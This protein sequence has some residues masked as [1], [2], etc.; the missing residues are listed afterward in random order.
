MN[1]TESDNLKCTI[2]NVGVAVQEGEKFTDE[3]GNTIEEDGLIVE[4]EAIHETITSNFTRYTAKGMKLGLESWTTPYNKPVIEHHD[5]ER[6]S[7][8]GRVLKAEFKET[9]EAGLPCVVATALITDKEAIKKIKDGR[10]LTTSIGARVENARCSI[11][12]YH[13]IDEKQGCPN[14]ARGSYYDGKL[15]VWNINNMYIKEISYVVV[16]SDKFSKNT[17]ILE[18]SSVKS[19]TFSESAI[20]N[21]KG[22]SQIMNENAKPG[23]NTAESEQGIPSGNLNIT[24]SEQLAEA[25]QTIIELKESAQQSDALRAEAENQVVA[26]E[27]ELRTVLL[28]A[29]NAVSIA[30]G[31]GAIDFEKFSKRTVESLKDK[32]SDDLEELQGATTAAKEETKPNDYSDIPVNN[33]GNVAT[34]ESAKGKEDPAVKTVEADKVAPVVNTT[35]SATDIPKATNPATQVDPE[36]VKVVSNIELKERY[37]KLFS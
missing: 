3:S 4:I 31:K 33:H 27:T 7:V 18:K 17:R 9:G 1:L 34:E 20:I 12:D 16:P 23:I 11:C 28:E 32:L 36:P 25:K 2:N 8:I 13:I 21:D 14:H 30:G 24:E 15:C 37:N 6:G 26:K 10:L 22:G 19:G 35:E 5:E 29:I